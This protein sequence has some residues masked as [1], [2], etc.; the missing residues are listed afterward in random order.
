MDE[1][2]RATRLLHMKKLQQRQRQRKEQRQP[3]RHPLAAL[4]QHQAAGGGTCLQA[5]PTLPAQVPA[6]PAPPAPACSARSCRAA[7]QGAS[8]IALVLHDC[9]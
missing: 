7:A 8:S 2:C 6:Q 1:S 5:D 9:G 4:C 3:T